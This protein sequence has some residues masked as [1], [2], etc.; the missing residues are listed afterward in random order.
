MLRAN[1]TRSGAFLRRYISNSCRRTLP[2]A[3]ILMPENTASSAFSDFRRMSLALNASWLA[4]WLRPECPTT[5]WVFFG[6][7]L[8]ITLRSDC[9][10]IGLPTP[11]A[12]GVTLLSLRVR[13]V[14]ATLGD[15]VPFGEPLVPFIADGED[16]DSESEPLS[17]AQLTL[18]CTLRRRSFALP[19]S[20]LPDGTPVPRSVRSDLVPRAPLGKKVG[21]LGRSLA[22]SSLGLPMW[23]SPLTSSM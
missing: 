4:R 12:A 6:P 8:V 1:C 22:P 2:S 13:P 16:L 19:L 15:G 18:S 7:F 17:T 21:A 23:P 14:L 9:L 10:P 3:R 20:L 5:K 11:A